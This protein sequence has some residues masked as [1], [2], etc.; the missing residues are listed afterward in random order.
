MR[1]KDVGVKAVLVA[2]FVFLLLL[3]PLFVIDG[4]A[5]QG[6][7]AEALVS[8]V[9]QERWP[10]GAL[11]GREPLLQQPVPA[12]RRFGKLS[13]S[14][15]QGP[16]VEGLEAVPELVEGQGPLAVTGVGPSANEVG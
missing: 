15:A 8:E 1:F 3:F 7:R 13:A 14:Q 5:T 9:G 10:T 6:A 11:A 12:L 2:G 16:V 4:V